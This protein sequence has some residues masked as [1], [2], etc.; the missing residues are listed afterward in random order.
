LLLPRIPLDCTGLRR[1]ALTAHPGLKYNTA[2][3]VRCFLLE[4][5]TSVRKPGLGHMKTI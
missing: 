1:I 2:A 4:K 3:L 5:N